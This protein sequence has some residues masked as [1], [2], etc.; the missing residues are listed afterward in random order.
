MAEIDEF[1]EFQEIEEI[2][3]KP[4]DIKSLK[5][6]LGGEGDE[7]GFITFE[8][9]SDEQFAIYEGSTQLDDSKWFVENIDLD[10]ARR[11]RDFLNYALNDDLKK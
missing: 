4:W 9:F 2:E 11:L 1:G 3:G 8:I 5:L 7:K 6:C 10:A